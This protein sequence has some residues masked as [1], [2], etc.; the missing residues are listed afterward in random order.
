MSKL[1]RNDAGGNTD[2]SCDIGKVGA[3]LL[4]EGLLAAGR[5]LRM[6]RSHTGKLAPSNRR[7]TAS[8]VALAVSSDRGVFD[9]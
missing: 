5:G 3:K 6:F 2:C 7:C 4:N 8:L 1:V 9:T